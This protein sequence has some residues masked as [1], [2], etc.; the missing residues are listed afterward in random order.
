[1]RK[2]F[3]LLALALVFA[4]CLPGCA[5]YSCPACGRETS[6]KYT[7]PVCY[8]KVCNYCS[9]DDHYLEEMYNSGKMEQYLTE[10]GY[11][12]LPEKQSAFSLYAYGFLSG[13][14]KGADGV[15]DDEV[16]ELSAWDFDLLQ[17]EYGIYGW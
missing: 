17:K 10:R 6:G 14:A 4:I 9:D 3:A 2:V 1:M 7:C 13:Y 8:S 15:I 5:K 11:I 16:N 12:V